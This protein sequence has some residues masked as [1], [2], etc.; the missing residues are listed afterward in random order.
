[1]PLL[2]LDEL[3]GPSTPGTNTVIQPL[4]HAAARFNI[5][6]ARVY[7]LG[8]GMS[9]HAT[10]NLALH[11]PTYFAAINPL[12]GGVGGAWQ[13]IRLV[14]LRNILTVVWHDSTDQI[15]PVK[16][17]REPV[18]ILRK[19]KFDVDYEETNNVGHAPSDEIAERQ[20]QKLRARTRLLYP[21]EV[22]LASNRPESMFNR[23]DWLQVYQMLNPGPDQR[24]R[25]Q[26]GT[27]LATISQ[28]SYSIS[29]AITAPNRV[30]VAS[31][32]VESFRLF[33]NDQMLDLTKP[34]T[35]IVN[36]KPRFEGKLKQ[37]IEEMLKD[38]LALGRGWRYYTAVVD[39]DFGAPRSAT[40][41]AT[42]PATPAR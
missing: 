20:Y 4:H 21:P 6:P 27:G 22:V 29:T 11:Y 33:L 42:K 24:L 31:Q 14:N 35:V 2:N 17:A 3:F 40:G 36:K 19:H 13:R 7:L 12:A 5:D 8:Q 15:I 32:N 10:W 18:N 16:W 9:A 1:M 34:V 41:P 25:F 37:S 30:E 23:N 39:I 26:H 38:Q 28:N